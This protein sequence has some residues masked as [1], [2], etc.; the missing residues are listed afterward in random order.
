MLPGCFCC[1]DFARLYFQGCFNFNA[2]ECIS[3]RTFCIEMRGHILNGPNLSLPP[4]SAK[5]PTPR[6]FRLPPLPV[7]GGRDWPYVLLHVL[8]SSAILATHILLKHR[9]RISIDRTV[10]DYNHNFSGLMELEVTAC[11]HPFQ[12]KGLSYQDRRR[13]S[14]IRSLIYIS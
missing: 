5:C 14:A 6:P 13:A 7:G 3:N 12:T 1:F 2:N 9:A 10:P 8:I 4:N 11:Q